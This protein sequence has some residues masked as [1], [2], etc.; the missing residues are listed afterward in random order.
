MYT[1]D[2]RTATGARVEQ[3]AAMAIGAYI[4][5]IVIVG[6]VGNGR[7]FLE[8]G[9]MRVVLFSALLV[10]ARWSGAMTSR[11]GRFSTRLAGAAAGLFVAGAIGAVITDGW[12]RNIFAPGETGAP[13][14]YAYVI[15]LSGMLFSLGAIGTGIAGRSAGPLA[16]V[17]ILGG[18]T[19]PLAIIS[20]TAGHV[21][22][23]ALWLVLCVG[24]I[25]ARSAS[26]DRNR[27]PVL[28]R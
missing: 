21:V 1:N 22:W 15:G 4:V 11:L 9:V 27:Q 13:P 26:A 16:V 20:D 2:E 7:H 10:F 6:L 25:R 24:L 19:F 18:A 3:L 14:W 8:L 5:Y 12:S 17:A 28:A 23:L